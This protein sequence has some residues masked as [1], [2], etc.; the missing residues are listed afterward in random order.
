MRTMRGKYSGF[1]ERQTLD[2]L[3]IILFNLCINGFLEPK[4]VNTQFPL[5]GWINL[6]AKGSD[7]MQGGPL[8]VNKVDFIDAPAKP[9]NDNETLELVNKMASSNEKVLFVL[10]VAILLFVSLMLHKP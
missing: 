10:R 2:Y 7:Y 5:D 8:T 4:D 1:N 3:Y 6:T 9:L